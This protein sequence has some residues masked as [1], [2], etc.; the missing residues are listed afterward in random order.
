M[1]IININIYKFNYENII[2]LF[3]I[4]DHLK[5]KMKYP[6]DV[7]C[8]QN[9]T[10]F[11]ELINNINQLRYL[12]SY[13]NFTKSKENFKHDQTIFENVLLATKV[14]L[15]VIL[16][17]VSLAGNI[18]I[19]VVIFFDKS[20]RKP[21]NLFIFNLALCDMAILISCTFVQLLM[22]IK[23]YWMFGELFC[24]L[25]SFLQMVSVLASV[26]TL[27]MIACDRYI[28]IMHPLK[29]KVYIKNRYY[30]LTICLIWIISI[31]ISIPTYMYRKYSEIKWLDYVETTCDDSGWPLNPKMNKNGCIIKTESEFKRIYYTFII[32]SLFFVPFLIMVCVY[33]I[34]IRKL[35]RNREDID[36][37][38][39]SNNRTN[40]IKNQKKGIIMLVAILVTFFVCWSPLELMILYIQ[41]AEKVTKF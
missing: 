13:F 16:I 10:Q 21:T 36:I 12:V 5:N 32:I 39:Q 40:L 30:Y 38:V 26:L 35:W 37:M 4:L 27:L 23:N 29:S 18:S 28:G 31:F 7:N 2:N 19:I 24:K 33:S 3:I 22:S 17:I 6:V 25:N 8:I 11:Y 20:K 15:Y 1:F 14:I 9:I 41:Y 34:M